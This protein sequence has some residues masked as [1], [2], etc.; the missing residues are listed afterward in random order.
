MISRLQDYLEPDKVESG[1]F[2]MAEAVRIENRPP[3]VSMLGAWAEETGSGLNLEQEHRLKR[4]GGE[5]TE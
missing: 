3:K 1:Q 5:L 4:E 2:H